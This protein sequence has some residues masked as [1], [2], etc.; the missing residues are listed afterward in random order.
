MADTMTAETDLIQSPRTHSNRSL[1]WPFGIRRL[2]F[3][4]DQCKFG[5]AC[6]AQ[7]PRTCRRA[8]GIL[9]PSDPRK[10]DPQTSCDG[11]TAQ[12]QSSRSK[13]VRLTTPAERRAALAGRVLRNRAAV[14]PGRIYRRYVNL[15]GS[16]GQNPRPQFGV[17]VT[18]L[19]RRSLDSARGGSRE[20]TPGRGRYL[21]LPKVL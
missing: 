1:S 9:P 13:P 4:S 10:F 14:G 18:L 3:E 19:S 5:T 16:T 6:R 20:R 21:N 15:G 8:V 12:G 17:A 11:L 2:V 7:H